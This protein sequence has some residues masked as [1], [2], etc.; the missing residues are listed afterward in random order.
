MPYAASYDSQNAPS[1]FGVVLTLGNKGNPGS[2]YWM[3]QLA[4]GTDGKVHH[5]SC[6]NHPGTWEEWKAL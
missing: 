1:G 3:F 6:V 4:F 5:R 2:T